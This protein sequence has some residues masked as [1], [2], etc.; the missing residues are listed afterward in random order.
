[1][2]D[3]KTIEVLGVQMYN[4][5]LDSF[6]SHVL[7][8]IS[9]ENPKENRCVSATGAHGIIYAKKNAFFKETLNSFY[10]NLPDGMPGVWVGRRKGA[11]EMKRCYGPDLFSKLMKTSVDTDAKHF[12]CGG[13]DGVAEKLQ[14]ACADKFGNQNIVGT[15]C[16]PFKKVEEYD[17]EGIAEQINRS[18]ADVV[19]V[20]ISTPKQEQFAKRL[21]EYTDTHF[22]ITV[23]AAFDFHIGELQQA[24]GWMQKAGLEWFFRLVVEPRRLYRRYL[25]IVPTFLFYGIKDVVTYKTSGRKKI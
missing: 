25:E 18:G 11:G 7:E 12:L 1:M 14:N 6:V 9:Q 23:G 21:S 3:D 13:K 2:R 15:Y 8:V 20:G 4:Q 17:Y 24:P 10:T 19:W 22:L 5:D 16:P